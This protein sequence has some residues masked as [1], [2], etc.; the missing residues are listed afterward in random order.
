MRYPD[1][2]TAERLLLEASEA[3]PGLWVG[4]SRNAAFCAKTIAAACGMDADKAYILGLLHDIG[5]RAGTG[6][7]QHI[8]HGCRDMTALGFADAARIAVTHSFPSHDLETYNGRFDCTAGE[9]REMG[10]LLQA[11]AFDDYDRLI[12]LCDSLA[13]PGRVCCVE[14][15]LIDVAL[16]N[17]VKG[18]YRAKWKAYFDIK[19]HFDALAGQ[20]IYRLFPQIAEAFL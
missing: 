17:G 13:L 18:D 3:N 11:F 20:N 12:Q 16:R 6:D 5:R 1:I 7:F 8:V 4:H 14:Q 2:E 9:K 15:R 19:D 10:T